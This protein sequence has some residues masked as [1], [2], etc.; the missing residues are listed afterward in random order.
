MKVVFIGHCLVL[1]SDKKTFESDILPL[2][3]ENVK[4]CKVHVGSHPVEPRGTPPHYGAEIRES[5]WAW[6]ARPSAMLF[7]RCGSTMC[8][9]RLGCWRSGVYQ[10]YNAHS[11]SSVTATHQLLSGGR[12]GADDMFAEARRWLGVH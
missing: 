1:D 11:I 4:I 8:V 10:L 12:H 5:L 3:I 6:T 9:S 2:L 7:R